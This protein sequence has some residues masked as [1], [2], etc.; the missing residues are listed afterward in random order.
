[1]KRFQNF[2]TEKYSDDYESVII[3]FNSKIVLSEFLYW[4]LDKKDDIC[5]MLNENMVKQFLDVFD[6]YDNED[7]AFYLRYVFTE[8][9][10]GELSCCYVQWLLDK[11]EQY[12]STYVETFEKLYPQSSIDLVKNIISNNMKS[13]TYDRRTFIRESNFEDEKLFE[14]V[15]NVPFIIS[16]R[17]ESLL[18][19]IKHPI[20]KKLIELSADQKGYTTEATLIDFDEYEDDKFLYTVAS[21]Y[22]DA[23]R[24]FK[25]INP[26]WDK[27]Q[28]Y[29]FLKTNQTIY[30]AFPSYIKIGR[31]INKLF[32]N[33]FSPSGR[34]SNTIE[35]F[36]DLIMTK[37]KQKFQK[38]EIV[39]GEDIVKYY[40]EDNYHEDAFNG[41]ELGN[42]CMRYDTCTD[43]I[44]FYAEN[45]DVKLI[46]MK[47]GKSKIVARALLWKIQYSMGKEIR[48]GIFMDRVYYTKVYQKNLLVQ[49]AKKQAWFYKKTQNNSA[50]TQIFDPTLNFSHIWNFKTTETFKPSSTGEYPYMDTLKWFYVDRNFLSN[51]LKYKENNEKVYFL[52]DTNGEYHVEKQGQYVEYYDDYF[53]KEDLIYCKYGDDYRLE[54]DAYYLEE[55]DAFATD[56]YAKRYCIFDDSGYCTLKKNAQK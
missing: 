56:D 9:G 18:K 13:P 14:E 19:K 1:M 50:D 34:E 15:D 46:I 4:I 12:G 23:I 28:I 8:N 17:L 10:K 48:E 24:R 49:Y 55:E 21:K 45:P 35:T 11:I 40:N 54:D 47:K 7:R 41:S 51:T 30:Y 33:E 39:D 22:I 53:N 2:I 42:S 16:Q 29:D 31:L 3:V 32:P 44:Q 5:P 37:R 6:E 25:N 20:A 36:V 26:S 43:S 52:E 38:I 27:S